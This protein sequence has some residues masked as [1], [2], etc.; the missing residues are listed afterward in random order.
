MAPYS[1]PSS[2]SPKSTSSLARNTRETNDISVAKGIR[3]KRP[4]RFGRKTFN[5]SNR[6]VTFA[7]EIGN[8]SLCNYSVFEISPMEQEDSNSTSNSSGKRSDKNLNEVPRSVNFSVLQEKSPQIS[9]KVL[10]LKETIIREEQSYTS[11][12]ICSQVMV[13]KC[14]FFHRNALEVIKHVKSSHSRVSGVTPI[15]V[16]HFPR[17]IISVDGS[18]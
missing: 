8:S 9:K 16:V 13:N 15:R 5:L 17:S 3:K 1:S 6:R 12:V 10:K 7:D 18:S 14:T 4:K 11:P 2:S